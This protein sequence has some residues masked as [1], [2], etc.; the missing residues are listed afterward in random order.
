MKNLFDTRTSSFENG[1]LNVLITMDLKYD[2][3]YRSCHLRRCL[4][5]THTHKKLVIEK[6]T[7]LLKS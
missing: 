7:K 5:N 4:T 6:Q 3:V 2:Q 1:S